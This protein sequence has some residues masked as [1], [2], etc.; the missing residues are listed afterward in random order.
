[1]EIKVK[2]KEKEFNFST[3]RFI[4]NLDSIYK[5][6]DNGIEFGMGL[7]MADVYLNQYSV[8]ELV[9]ILRA[10]SV[11]PISVVD[12]QSAIEDFANENGDLEPLF[13]GV[14]EEMGKSPMA[15]ATLKKLAKIEKEEMAR[16]KN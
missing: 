7:M 5:A 14:K 1:M 3:F 6:K 4:N 10:A 16:R 13:E 8:G 9:N 15:K 2:G 11:E 12:M